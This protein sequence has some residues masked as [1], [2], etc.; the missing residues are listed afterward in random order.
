[1]PRP[2]LRHSE[3][4]A[5]FREAIG[6]PGDTTNWPTHKP[7]PAFRE[8]QDDQG[9]QDLKIEHFSRLASTGNA[10]YILLPHWD[11]E[12]AAQILRDHHEDMQA[13]HHHASPMT[14]APQLVDMAKKGGFTLHDHVGDAPTNGYMVSQRKDTEQTWP[15]ESLKPEHIANYANQHARQL[16]SPDNYLGGWLDNGK[17][18]LDVSTH[19]PSIDRAASDGVRA[20]QLAIYDLNKGQA[21]NTPDAVWQAGDPGLAVKPQMRNPFTSSR[22]FYAWYDSL[23]DHDWTTHHLGTVDDW[24]RGRRLVAAGEL[25]P[26]G[27]SSATPAAWDIK[28]YKPTGQ[29]LGTHHAQV[30]QHPVNGEKWLVKPTPPGSEFLA[31]LD[32]AGNAIASKSGVDSPPTFKTQIGTQPAS[33]QYMYPGA[34]NAFPN[35]FDAKQISPEDLLTVQKHHALDWMLSNHDSHVGQFIRNQDGKLIG[36]DKG[37]AFRYSNN[38]KLHWNFHPNADYN[39]QEP[40]YNTLYRE[41]AK[42]NTGPINDPRQGEYGKYVQGLQDMDDDEYRESL[43]PYAEGAAKSGLLGDNFQK[44]GKGWAETPKFKPNDVEG[45]LNHAVQRKNTLVKDMGDLYDRAYSHRLTGEKI[46]KKKRYISMAVP[47]PMLMKNMHEQLGTHGAGVFADPQGKWLIKKPP[48]DAPFMVP[49]DKATAHLQ[50]RVGLTSSETHVVPWKHNQDVTA[51][52][53]IPGATQAFQEPP[54]LKDLDSQELM[55]LQK[56]QALD[57][58]IGNHDGHVGNFMRTQPNPNHPKGELVGIDKGQ[59]FKYYGRDRLDPTFHPNFYAREP[60]YNQLWRDHADGQGNMND[61]RTGE[62]G[63]FVNRIQDIGDDE[64]KNIFR[65]YAENASHAG[66]LANIADDDHRRRLGP[67][68]ITPNDPE[69]FLEAIARRKNSLGKDLGDLYDRQSAH[70]QPPGSVQ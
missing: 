47:D 61:P 53:M 9:D 55:T 41:F 3:R 52:R 1:M 20:N 39:E 23:P 40:V 58:L 59:S 16:A 51:V 5:I 32:V 33:S 26:P 43:R 60:V 66:L 54:H 48:P 28:Q 35:G 37:Q 42:G 6:G 65:P 10:R 8:Q 31:D 44:K 4:D 25:P 19:R 63:D 69:E 18:Y 15:I 46:A 38:D 36:I 29:E 13:T 57:W 21:I 50:D 22:E 49:L 12:E 17:F 14:Q 24:E 2:L 62:L 34:K 56:H 67:S 11:P 45:F 64:L 68:T 30:W 7:V 70:K 27:D